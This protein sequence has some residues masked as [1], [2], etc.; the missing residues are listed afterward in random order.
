MPEYLSPGVYVQEVNT[1]PRPIEGVGTACAAFVGCAPGGPINSPVLVTNWTQYANVFSGLDPADPG[2]S[3]PAPYMRGFFLS[4]A[5]YGYFLN[6]GGR[7]YV[8]RVMPGQQPSGNGSA[9]KAKTAEAAPAVL[10]LPSKGAKSVPSLAVS[11]KGTPTEP[12]TV[13]VDPPSGDAPAE[14]DFNL[15]IRMGS[16]EEIYERVTLGKAKGG[17]N[18]LEVVNTASRLVKL[19]EE[20]APGPLA[21]RMPAVG[22]YMLQAQVPAI[23]Y[24]VAAKPQP[25]DLIGDV[26]SRS[27]L[28]GLEIAEDVTMV[29]CPDLM[30]LHQQGIFDDD[31]VKAVQLNMIA[32][33]ETMGDRVAILDAPLGLSPQSVKAWR[34][35]VTNYDSKYAALYYPWIKVAGPD[36]A[37]L[38][39]P[40]SGHIAGVYARS[41][42]ERGVHKAPANEVIRGALE[43]TTA[44]TKGEQDTLNPNGVNCSRSFAG[45]GLRGWGARTLSSDPAWR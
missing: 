15:R 33:C 36:G 18:V 10:Q 26:A 38:A 11:V 6:G 12:I 43:T 20:Q 31:A 45:R 32:H 41:D 24:T 37:P 21:E 13:N 35:Q 4:H 44:I 5:V 25:S 34:E 14:G 16:V 22:E 23:A 2:S 17:R 1:G 3:R 30:A 7:C 9:P 28:Q 27:G 19:L 8:V 39:I 29:C 42:N 40:S